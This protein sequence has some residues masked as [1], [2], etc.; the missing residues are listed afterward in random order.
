MAALP[1][2]ASRLPPPDA[3][4]RAR[5]EALLDRILKEIDAEGFLPFD[6]FMALALYAPGLGYY[7]SDAEKL[8]PG[9]DFVTAPELTPLFAEALS[10]PLAHWVEAGLDTMLELGPGTGTLAAELLPALERRGRLPRRYQ[11][12][13]LSAALRARQQRTIAARAPHLLE[14]VQ[15]LERLPESIEGIVLGNE[16]LDAVPVSLVRR[17]HDAIEELGVVRAS[18]AGALA[19]GSRPARAPLRQAAAALSLPA[20]YTTEIH[21]QAQALIRS[22]GAAL[23]R[24]AL[25][26]LDYGFP[27]LEYYHPQ[28]T[29]GTLVCHYRH[30]MHPDP[31]ACVGLQDISA[32]LDFSA[33]ASAGGESGLQLAGYT[34]QA[35]FL[36]DC[37]ILDALA[38]IGAGNTLQYAKAAGAVQ[39][40][41]SPAEMGELVKAV[42]FTRGIETAAV[43]GF[44]SSDMRSRL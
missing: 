7:A 17:S 34:T 35:H 23:G 37:G 40:L 41:L 9:G 32:H 4:E 2:D 43:P 27:A 19:W 11:L 28:R 10:A 20:Q 42:A 29:G 15:W 33:L 38:A 30:R 44:R 6:R 26:F 3:A 22:L 25:L 12:L 16:V 8:G 18:A 24:G 21:L 39:K 36:I 1:S 5:S 13:E 14:R 31:L